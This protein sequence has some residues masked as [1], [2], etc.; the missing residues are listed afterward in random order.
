MENNAGMR[1]DCALLVLGRHF[2]PGA[3]DGCAYVT[4]SWV[5]ALNLLVNSRVGRPRPLNKTAIS[6]SQ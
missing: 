3:P 1:F 6:R 2:L 5:V 4:D